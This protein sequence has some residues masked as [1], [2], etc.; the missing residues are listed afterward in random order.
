V[1][2]HGGLY[3]RI[4]VDEA[5]AAA[6]VAGVRA[7]DPGLPLMGLPDSVVLR[8]AAE[9]GLTPIPEAFADRAYTRAGQLVS[10]REPGAVITDEHAVVDRAVQ[11]ARDGKV[12][13]ITGEMVQVRARSLCL[14][15]DT[16]G[17]AEHAK[18][19]R[20]ALE[21]AGVRVAAFA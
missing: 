9:A 13:A 5:Q 17:A 7:A 16:P 10:R 12:T 15:G 2:P 3:N 4:A 19:V 18:R 6:V 8:L 1:K 11:I 14:H 20:A 21:A